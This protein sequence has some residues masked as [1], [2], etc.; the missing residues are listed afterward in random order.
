MKRIMREV[1]EGN[2][3]P[4]E[5][6]KEEV[7]HLQTSRKKRNADRK[8]VKWL[9]MIFDDSLDFDVHWKSRIAKARRALG[10]LSRVGGSQWGMCLGG[11]KK[12]YKG[13]IRSIATWGTEL[14]WRGQKS[15]EKEF[16]QLQYQA[17]WKATGAV[18]GTSAER[19]NQ[20][21]G[22]EDVSTHLNNNQVRFVARQVED[23]S[24]VGNLLPV[25]FGDAGGGVIDDELAE[26]GD[27][28]RWDVHGLQWVAKEGK[29]DGFVS[30][31]TRMVSILPEGKP[32]W[33]GLCRKVEVEEVELCPVN[34]PKDPGEWEKEI[35]KA[36]TGGDYVFSDGSLLER[37]N[38]KDSA[39]PG[40]WL[41]ALGSHLLSLYAICYRSML[42]LY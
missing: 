26:G 38:C 37:G 3:L 7:L 16:S 13:M 24:K 10:A 18:Q 1:V 20:M 30:T 36:G 21:A 2:N 40:S 33:G 17:L 4:L 35:G 42:S 14:G 23:P 32:L 19:V 34:D 5:A 39:T 8:H 6:E 28:K 31:L 25:G 15:L 11:W 41:A 27:G 12:A 29:K 22:V 9:D